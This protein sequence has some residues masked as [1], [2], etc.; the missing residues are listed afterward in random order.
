LFVAKE[1]AARPEARL[2]RSGY[3][4]GNEKQVS[5]DW[6]RF[7]H[8]IAAIASELLAPIIS[9][10]PYLAS[11]PPKKQVLDG[12]R[13][14]WKVRGPSGGSPIEEILLSVR[15]VRNNVFHGGKFPEGPVT[16]P[17]RDEQ[18]IGDCLAVLHALLASPGLPQA[19]AGYF[20]PDA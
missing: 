8:D 12:T 18:L 7:A 19:V 20:H 3:V 2:K 11:H 5:A 14:V 10:C 1:L 17:L 6:D 9:S 13:L 16:E 15:T 4:A